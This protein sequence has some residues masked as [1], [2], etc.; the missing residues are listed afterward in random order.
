MEQIEKKS[1]TS[2]WKFFT[3]QTDHTDKTHSFF[4]EQEV[5]TEMKGEIINVKITMWIFKLNN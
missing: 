5:E 3:D 4:E 2:L 1:I